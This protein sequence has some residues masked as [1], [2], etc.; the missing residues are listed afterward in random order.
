L[1]VPATQQGIV[2]G[3]AG[4]PV[5]S[6]DGD[7][8]PSCC[9]QQR[10]ATGHHC[11]CAS[12]AATTFT[13]NNN[14][15]LGSTVTLPP[16]SGA[17]AGANASLSFSNAGAT[18]AGDARSGVCSGG[19]LNGA[20]GGDNSSDLCSAGLASNLQQLLECGSGC[21]RCSSSFGTKQ[22][23]PVG[24]MQQQQQ[25]QYSAGGASRCAAKPRFTR[26]LPATLDMPCSS[27]GSR[28]QQIAKSGSSSSRVGSWR[29]PHQHA[30]AGS[31]LQLLSYHGEVHYAHNEKQ[32]WPHLSIALCVSFMCVLLVPAIVMYLRG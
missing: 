32:V 6:A 16:C 29:Q 5:E 10:L 22:Q 11:S 25:L 19:G 18:A 17:A 8:K 30:P 14:S 26:R 31:K 7:I 27:G 2:D 24:Q 15:I 20:S 28:H 12:Y 1:Q 21:G 13:S 9:W 4:V 3:A 23:S